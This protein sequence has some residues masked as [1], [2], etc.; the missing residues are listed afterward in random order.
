M[1]N[2]LVRLGVLTCALAAA[3]AVPIPAAAQ[4]G[5]YLRLAHLSPDTPKVDVTV[6]A[7]DDPDGAQVIKGVGYGDVSAYQRIAAGTY[8]IAMRPA[9][10]DPKTD[11]VISATLDAVGGRAYTVAGLGEFANLALRVLNDD[12]SL[13]AAG[14]ARMRVV[15]AAPLA[16][17]L[18]IRRDGTSVIDGA[19]FG[20]P[21]PY[22]MV[23]AGKATLTVAPVDTAPTTLPVTLKAGGV[24]TILVLQREGVLSAAV[25]LDARGSAVVPDGAVETGF[26]GTSGQDHWLLVLL[27]GCAAAAVGAL[28]LAARRRVA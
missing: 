15:N 28:V 23:P 5:A 13:P 2:L 26:G 16:G 7:F 25:R 11:P 10:A 3:V 4:T 20:D 12:I 18:S 27:L 9:G 19:A 24:Y 21:S 1:R 8:S 17:E 22:T 14:K 6:S